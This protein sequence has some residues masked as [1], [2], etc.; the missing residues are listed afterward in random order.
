MSKITEFNAPS[1]L[2]RSR[3]LMQQK[4]NKRSKEAMTQ[5]E[6]TPE[7]LPTKQDVKLLGLDDDYPEAIAEKHRK[8]TSIKIQLANMS[9]NAIIDELGWKPS[10]IKSEV[11]QQMIDEYRAEVNQPV[12]SIDPITGDEVVYRYKP[13]SV[14]LLPIAPEVNRTL[15]PAEILAIRL[16]MTKKLNDI[17]TI[18]NFLSKIAPA[19]NKLLDENYNRDAASAIHDIVGNIIGVDPII[20]YE[21]KKEALREAVDRADEDRKQIMMDVD[22][23]RL[24]LEHNNDM[25][26]KN[27]INVAEAEKQTRLKVSKAAEEL[28]VL[29]SGRSI[30]GQ[31][32]GETDEDYRQRLVDIGKE[33]LDDDEIEREAGVLQVVKAKYNL[34]DFLSDEGKIET[35]IKKLTDDERT[36]FNTKNPAIKKNY[37]DTYGFNNNI[38][39]VFLNTYAVI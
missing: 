21:A 16:E 6:I 24:Q 2:T 35:I 37:L 27:N 7:I 3:L 19:E 20:K 25:I 26:H 18:N 38:Q 23:L 36:E 31:Q 4:L 33:V 39:F 13:S 1:D 11:T 9:K 34:K 15:T 14:D 5:R 30:P 28:R 12:K 17:G 32:P 10:K 22:N 29:N 8:A